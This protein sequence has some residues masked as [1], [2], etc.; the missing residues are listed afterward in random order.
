MR[1]ALRPAAFLVAVLRARVRAPLRAAA[2]LAGDLRAVDL[3]AVFFLP[4]VFFAAIAYTSI[5]TSDEL[6]GVTRLPFPMHVK[7][8]VLSTQI[9]HFPIQV[10]TNAHFNM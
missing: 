2:F 7:Q 5:P 1:A 8:Y 6:P 4:V 9:Q 10:R 3:R